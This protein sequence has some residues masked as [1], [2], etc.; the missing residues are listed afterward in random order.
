M[1]KDNQK[2]NTSYIFI[3]FTFSKE[4]SFLSFVKMIEDSDSWTIIHD[5]IIYMLKFIADKFDSYDTKN[6]QCFHFGFVPDN[7][8]NIVTISDN[9]K[10]YTG[11]HK[12]KGEDIRFGFKINGIQLYCF[13]T[14]VCIMAFRITSDVSD[15]LLLSSE[16]Y[17][18]K[19]VSKEKIYIND[20]STTMLDIAKA[21]LA[22]FSKKIQLDF[23]YFA[24]PSTERANILTFLEVEPQDSYRYELFY[25]R[26]CYSDGFLYAEN[27]KLDSEEIFT[28]SKDTVWGISPEAAICL[29]C[30]GFGRGS[31]ILGK[32]YENFN[33]QYL[34][35][36]VQLL[37]QKFVL[38]MF[39]TQIGVG[40]YNSLEKLEQYRSELYEFETD[41]VFSLVTEVPQYQY[42]Y[43][44]MQDAFALKKMYED[45]HEPLVSLAETR[46]L[47]SENEQ[48]IRDDTV[49]RSLLV[50]SLL[51][52]FSALIDSFDFVESFFGWFLN[53]V[54]I[55]VV[56]ILCFFAITIALF[57][58]VKNIRKN[59]YDNEK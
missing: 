38:Y 20:S 12:Y 34:F 29:A 11:T 13:S 48:K 49:N 30:P 28:P 8:S 9:G 7:Y 57:Y 42:L 4:I 26:R 2:T 25:L 27:E 55:K 31:F 45:V 51:S 3:P 59:K 46:R 18:L 10:Y 19:K 36:Y 52:F 54:G 35:M 44:K 6:C 58:V 56:Q 53:D 17:N 41:F 15:P 23:F 39:L 5:E 33:A 32:F 1:K 50:L 14:S 16:L 47:A 40:A 24:N 37:H 21:I 43:D 22:D